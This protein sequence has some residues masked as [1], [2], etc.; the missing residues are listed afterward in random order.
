MFILYAVAVGLLAGFLA[1]GG[2]SG[3]ARLRIRWAPVIVLG[4]VSQVILFSGPVAERVGSLGPPLY[5]GSTLLVLAAVIRNR[6]IPGIPVVIAGAVCNLAAVVGN[7]G[8][9]PASAAAL[10]ASGKTAPVV[11]SNSLLASDPA[12]WPLTDIFALPAWMPLANVFSVG[13]VLI[14]IGIALIA[15]LAMRGSAAAPEVAG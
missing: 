3:L 9:M 6:A 11:Y 7:G 15:V 14:G 4:L 8:Y 5:V 12:L 10:E 13:D 2:I 1:G